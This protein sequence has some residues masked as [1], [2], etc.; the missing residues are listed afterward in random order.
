[1]AIAQVNSGSG[2]AD[3][4]ISGL[5]CRQ[6]ASESLIYPIRSAVDRIDLA[7]LFPNPLPLEIELGSG[8]GSFLAEYARQHPEHNFIGVERL[9]GRLRKLDRKSRRAR[10]TNLRGLR[11]ESAYFLQYL[12]PPH[13][14]E[15]LHIYF[16]DPWPKRKHRRNRLINERFPSL[17]H[18]V[19]AAGGIVY[20]RTDDQ[21]YFEQMAAVF[22]AAPFFRGVET[23]G[24]LSELLTDFE[25]DFQA[26]GIA[27]RRAAYKLLAR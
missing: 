22:A 4:K 21:D 15:A 27:T 8:D 24:E 16:P 5:T 18:E 26:K 13:S 9:L 20:L 19:L 17:A 23:P 1:M 2:S 12:L 14:A 10:L 3:E 25:T 6:P 7:S 11:I